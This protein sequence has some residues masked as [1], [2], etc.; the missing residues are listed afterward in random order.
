MI[1]LFKGREL[2]AGML[3]KVYRNLHTG[4]FSIKCMKSNLIV[5][6]GTDFNLINVQAKVNQSG[7]ERVLREQQKNVHA[8]L[9]GEYTED[10]TVANNVELYYN[11]YKL[12][13]FINKKTGEDVDKVEN[14]YFINNKC[15]I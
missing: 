14:V 13:S 10:K 1:K 9:V 5:A 8:Y 6:H 2:K 11:P 15:F 12:S 7:R 3:V 4:N